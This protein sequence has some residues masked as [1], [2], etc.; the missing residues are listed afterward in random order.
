MGVVTGEE[1][2]ALAA[3][4]RRLVGRG[5]GFVSSLLGVRNCKGGRKREGGGKGGER[6]R[7][8]EGRG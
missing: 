4:G 2:E 3:P 1:M 7:G 5:G 6:V 8:R